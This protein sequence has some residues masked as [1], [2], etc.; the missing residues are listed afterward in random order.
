VKLALLRVTVSVL[1]LPLSL[2]SALAKNTTVGIYAIVSQ[3]MF[4]P[5]DCVRISGIFVVPVRMSSGAYQKPQ[6]GYLY[7]TF[8]PGAEQAIRRDWN[9]LKAIAGSGHVVAF[10]Q[11]WVPNPYDPQGNPHHSL[12]V[13]VHPES[14]IGATPDVYPIPLPGGVT[15]TEAL[16]HDEDRD[17]DVDKITAQLQEVWRH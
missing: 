4:E 6:R 9:E 15:K 8:E 17:P 5:N 10:G 14:E 3:V 13:T 2:S 7:L 12:E 1:L 11:Y 16:V